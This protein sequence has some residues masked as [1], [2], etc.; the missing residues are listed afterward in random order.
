MPDR[1]IRLCDHAQIGRLEPEQRSA[2]QGRRYL[3]RTFPLALV[4]SPYFQESRSGFKGHLDHRDAQPSLRPEQGLKVLQ[5]AHV[6]TCARGTGQQGRMEMQVDELGQEIPLGGHPARRCR[7]MNDLVN[8]V[9]EVIE[10]QGA[11]AKG[12]QVDT[13]YLQS[14]QRKR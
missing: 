7:S 5:I 10:M 8:H 3:L 12:L 1:L 2:L 11:R 6:L 14:Q 9:G 13:R 4:E